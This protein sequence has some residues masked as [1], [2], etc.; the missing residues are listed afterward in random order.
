MGYI[1][2]E[3][4]ECKLDDGTLL[5]NLDIVNGCKNIFEIYN[6]ASQNFEGPFTLPILWDKEA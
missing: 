4:C 6:K 1:F 5:S 3:E 2:D